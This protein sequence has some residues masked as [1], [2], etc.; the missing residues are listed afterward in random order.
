MQNKSK[1][2]DFQYTNVITVSAAHMIHDIYSSFLAPLLPFLIEKLGISYSLAGLLSVFQRLPSLLNPLVG[3]LADR[4][5][6]KTFLI[7]SPAL[8]TV[9]MSL[10][11][12]A[13][14][15]TAAVILLIVMGISST[16]FHVPAPVII[17]NLSGNRIGKGMSFY[18]L[19]GELARTLGPLT[20]LGAVSLWGLEGS[21]K[22]TP[23]GLLASGVL[24]WRLHTVKVQNHSESRRPHLFRTL[25]G[26][27]PFFLTLSA[28][29]FFRALTKN[30]FTTFLPTF[31]TAKG[32][33]AWTGGGL[34]SIL[35]LSGAAG[36]FLSGS[37]SDK[38]G[39]KPTLIIISIAAPVLM[40][41]FII[42]GTLIR[43]PVLILL[44]F[45][46][47]ASG[48]VLLAL[49]QDNGSGRPAL[50]NGIY[51]TIN[52]TAGSL[53]SVLIGGMGDLWTLET[54]FKIAALVSLLGIPAVWLLPGGKKDHRN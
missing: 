37:I 5:S 25:R 36:T 21:W 24:H 52:F 30:A 15:Y 45:F 20:I 10:L 14:S 47:F 17:R 27:A 2:S 9:V 39:R 7:V 40:W 54:S 53:V 35:Q 3:I 19:G 8:T 50:I 43:I 6:M 41:I 51:M 16:M 44:G 29:V 1:T 38:I 46:I 42:S 28:V 13:P 11:G 34:L 18:M 22:L 49:V 23:F 4:L 26:L 12:L 31:M 48:P 32:A 33:S